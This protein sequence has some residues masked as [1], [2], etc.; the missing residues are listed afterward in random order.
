MAH[1]IIKRC[2]VMGTLL[3]TVSS[4]ILAKQPE[5]V[6]PNKT[7]SKVVSKKT[8]SK[9][10]VKASHRPIKRAPVLSSFH[11][12][13]IPHGAAF[14][15]IAGISYA[16]IDN[17][18]YKR[19][20][21]TYVYVEQVPVVSTTTQTVQVA[22]AQVVPSHYG[23]MVNVLP[24]RVTTVTVN[25]ATFYVDGSDWYAPIAGTNQF[26]IVEPQF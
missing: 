20:N 19:S 26:V 17:T 6:V 22:P 24:S 1:S 25:G 14:V 8:A 5:K 16:V 11:H 23:K 7:V 18:Y 13:R 9:V 2:I 3:L 4:P 15:I 12:K 21:D 10:V